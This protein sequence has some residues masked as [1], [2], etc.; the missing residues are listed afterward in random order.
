MHFCVRAAISCGAYARQLAVSLSTLSQPGN[1]PREK[2]TCYWVEGGGT[3]NQRALKLHRVGSEHRGAEEESAEKTAPERGLGGCIATSNTD[4]LHRCSR[5]SSIKG[6]WAENGMPGKCF[7]TRGATLATCSSSRK[8]SE[9][10]SLGSG[11]ATGR[12]VENRAREVPSMLL[13]NGSIIHGQLC[14]SD[15]CSV[16]SNRE[17]K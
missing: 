4:R 13:L 3:R 12:T 11:A 15:P 9:T 7:S 2:R 6:K 1:V 5:C 8:R 16:R 10:T 17:W 14:C